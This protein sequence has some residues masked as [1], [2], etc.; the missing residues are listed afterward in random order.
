MAKKSLLAMALVFLIIL[1]SVS[2]WAVMPTVLSYQGKLTDT[3]GVP[4]PDG[5]YQMRFFFYDDITAGTELWQEQQNVSVADGVYSVHLGYT[6]AFPA[7][8][9]VDNDDLYLEVRI[10]NSSTSSWETLS[11]RQQVVC[12][13][14]SM[15]AQYA[16]KAL[17]GSITTVMIAD[18]AVESQK[19]ANSAI[20]SVKVASNAI[21]SAK[22][23]DGTVSYLDIQDGATLEEIK[24]DDGAGSGL[25]ADRLDGYEASAFSLGTHWHSFL[26]ASDGA[27]TNAVAVD[28]IGNVAMG[29]QVTDPDG[30]GLYVQNYVYDRAAV[31]GADQSGAYIY[32]EGLLGV[33]AP[34]GL[35]YN[36]YNIGVLGLKPNLGGNGA[37]V[38]G[39][40]NDSNNSPNYAMYAIADGAA[41]GTSYTNY[42]I[43]AKAANAY[44]NYGVY[45]EASTSNGIAYGFYGDVDAT[46]NDY[47]AYGHYVNVNRPSGTGPLYGN[48]ALVDNDGTTGYTYGTYSWAYSSDSSS[49]IGGYFG[50][51]DQASTDSG[52]RISVY[53][54]TD[55]NSAS[56]SFALYAYGGDYAGYFMGDVYVS[57]TI[58]APSTSSIQPHKSDPKKEIVYV[59]LEGPEHAVFIRGNATLKNGKA[60]LEMPEEWQQVAAEEGITVNLTPVGS[61]AP[62]YA[63]SVSK[64]EVTVRVAK[65]GDKD[66]SFSY[67]IMAK[68]D[69]FQEHE[70]IQENKHFTTDGMSSWQFE[71]R[72]AED[73]LETRAIGDMLKSNG[74]LDADG[75][76]NESTASTLGWKVMANEEDPTYREA[77]G[78]TRLE[79]GPEGKSP[80]PR[81]SQPEPEEVKPPEQELELSRQ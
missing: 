52:N 29:G 73:S 71:N 42:G 57:G 76:L 55:N 48:Y 8:F 63:E 34:T 14:F 45:S 12:S 7:T 33:L 15:K 41:I 38:Y 5:T 20:T 13:A 30:H 59:S 70:A 18:G 28:A 21:T 46:T 6:T 25:D 22:I 53:A 78:M 9:F 58:Y 23:A 17:D 37:A 77:H 65:G 35:P 51:V 66:A 43:Y 39:W 64:S 1:M 10:Y 36:P 56:T 47:V 62:L 11:P 50:A 49:A 32:A 54:Y 31:R 80:P 79:D 4:V 68:R 44:R 26:N 2:A 75:K 27:P 60:T 74:I 72:Y 24:D 19:V 67:Y 61:W 81:P 3:S 69:G 40:N 16:E